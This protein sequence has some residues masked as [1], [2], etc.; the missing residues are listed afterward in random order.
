VYRTTVMGSGSPAEA[1]GL[2]GISPRAGK[3]GTGQH[4]IPTAHEANIFD[5]RSMQQTGS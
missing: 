2:P 5:V 1:S 3:T 4:M